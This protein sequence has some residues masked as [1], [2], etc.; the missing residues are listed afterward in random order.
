[1][2]LSDLSDSQPLQVEGQLQFFSQQLMPHSLA[3]SQA[4]LAAASAAHTSSS[5]HGSADAACR[6]TVSMLR[7]YKLPRT[8][9]GVQCSFH[10]PHYA[11]L[12]CYWVPAPSSILWL[13]SDQSG[14][15][16]C[17]EAAVILYRAS[18]LIQADI[19]N[20]VNQLTRNCMQHRMQTAV[21]WT[22]EVLSA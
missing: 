9:A 16:G 22:I 17:C 4:C 3:A 19:H 14:D 12:S 6:V 5:A 1:M 21:T 8:V 10:S 20:G 13:Y 2:L 7:S 11:R 18:T 15:F